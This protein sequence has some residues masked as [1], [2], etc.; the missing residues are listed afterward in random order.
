MPSE[1]A[2]A[3]P[4]LPPA[5]VVAKLPMLIGLKFQVIEFVPRPQIDVAAIPPKL[6]RSAWLIGLLKTAV[7]PEISQGRRVRPEPIRL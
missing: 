2:T 7:M 6:A 4:P 5:S 1:S 3:W